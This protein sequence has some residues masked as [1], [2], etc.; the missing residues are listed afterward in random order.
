[1]EDMIITLAEVEGKRIEDKKASRR[2]VY[3]NLKLSRRLGG[4][5]DMQ[6]YCSLLTGNHTGRNIIHITSK[7]TW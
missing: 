5:K 2:V 7:H 4:S 6:N 3:V 1:M